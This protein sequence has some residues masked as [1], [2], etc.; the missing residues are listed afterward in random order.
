[1]RTFLW[2]YCILPWEDDI[3]LKPQLPPPPLTP[4]SI[5]VLLQ[6]VTQHLS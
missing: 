1:M 3:N 4:F 6:T 2:I 5:V